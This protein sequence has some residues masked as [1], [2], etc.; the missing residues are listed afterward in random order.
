MMV[1]MRRSKETVE[2]WVAENDKTLHLIQWLHFETAPG[3]REHVTMLRCEIYCN[4]ED[5]LCLM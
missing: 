5:K 1:E 2:K 3:D 4:F